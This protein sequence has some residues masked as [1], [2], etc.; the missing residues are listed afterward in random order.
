MYRT[1]SHSDNSLHVDLIRR[2]SQN[3]EGTLS[4]SFAVPW[5]LRHTGF[6]L[7]ISTMASLFDPWQVIPHHSPQAAHGTKTVRRSSLFSS[8]S[9]ATHQRRMLGAHAHESPSLVVAV[10]NG[11]LSADPARD[12]TE[13]DVLTSIPYIARYVAYYSQLG[14]SHV[15]VT[16][17]LDA[18]SALME[19]IVKALS[20]FIDVGS[21]TLISTS[22]PGVDGVGG[23]QGMLLKPSFAQDLAQTMSLYYVKGVATHLVLASL[24]ELVH[25]KGTVQNMLVRNT[26]SK[27][28][29]HE[30]GLHSEDHGKKSCEYKHDLP[31]A[32]V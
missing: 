22:F 11:V 29:G 21:L 25:T 23:F 15:F 18:T 14:V 4:I 20:S 2:Q 10:V 8:G 24:S 3:E 28:L 12:P 13:G 5:K 6:G 27:G 19:I 7:N 9:R 17:P 32:A 16:L 31:S 30:Q 1:L 26:R